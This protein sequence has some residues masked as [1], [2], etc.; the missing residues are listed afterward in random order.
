MKICGPQSINENYSVQRDYNMAAI[1]L[2]GGKISKISKSFSLCF[3]WNHVFFH[4]LIDTVQHSVL[5]KSVKYV[6]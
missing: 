6:C 2:L 5:K 3:K 4:S 1:D